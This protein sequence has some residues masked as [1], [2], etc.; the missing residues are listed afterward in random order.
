M[1]NC[2]VCG[3]SVNS[4]SGAC[5]YCNQ[6]NQYQGHYNY[7]P[8][9]Q[10]NPSYHNGQL[11]GGM[12]QGGLTNQYIYDIVNKILGTLVRIEEKLNEKKD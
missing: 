8:N 11:Q 1:N 5:Y 10:Y 2:I 4:I 12:S 6:K 3:N 7:G 9:Y